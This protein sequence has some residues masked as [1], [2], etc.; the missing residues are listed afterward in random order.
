M[1]KYKCWHDQIIKSAR[2]RPKSEETESHHIL[3]RAMGG[4]DRKENL[5]NLTYRE[6]FLVH[7]LLTKFVEPR[8]TRKMLWA[9][10]T[11]RRSSPTRERVVSG[12]QFAVA[13]QA[14]R[15]SMLG[16]ELTPSQKLW[17]QEHAR[18][19]GKATTGIPKTAEHCAAVSAA[20][21]G[22]VQSEKQLAHLARMRAAKN[23]VVSQETRLKI[24]E[25]G[26]GRKRS[27]ETIA[28]FSKAMT[29]QRRTDE[30]RAKMRASRLKYVAQQRGELVTTNV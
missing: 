14:H 2:G 10:S 30:S 24:S 18:A 4:L 17:L 22:K 11:M 25:T 12:W 5:V 21:T 3:P 23:P 16:R 1:N 29:G 8:F 20:K 28:K 15:D 13:R 26:Q 7:W 6:H 9:L 19:I 27:P